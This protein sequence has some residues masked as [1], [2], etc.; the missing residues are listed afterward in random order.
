MAVHSHGWLAFN[1]MNMMTCKDWKLRKTRLW[2]PIKDKEQSNKG[3]ASKASPM[4][5]TLKHTYIQ[6]Q[7]GKTNTSSFGVEVGN[8]IESSPDTIGHSKDKGCSWLVCK[9]NRVQSGRG[10]GT[11]DGEGT[12]MGDWFFLDYLVADLRLQHL[13]TLFS[14]PSILRHDPPC[15]KWSLL[16]SLYQLEHLWHLEKRKEKGN[17]RT[18][19]IKN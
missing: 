6:V 2:S 10:E 9:G 8:S 4:S 5:T 15:Q 14:P 3:V 19:R 7:M 12:W 1:F 16:T 13:G 11:K 18:P 17:L